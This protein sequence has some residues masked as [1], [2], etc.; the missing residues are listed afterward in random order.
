[1]GE[2]CPLTMHQSAS[3]FHVFIKR[4]L[5]LILSAVV[6]SYIANVGLVLNVI[7]IQSFDL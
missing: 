4:A 2:S 5:S 7:D 1:M 3:V 6:L